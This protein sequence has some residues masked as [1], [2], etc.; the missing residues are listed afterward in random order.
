MV[1]TVSTIPAAGSLLPSGSGSPFLSPPN[2]GFAVT[3]PLLINDPD[4]ILSLFS[5]N[6]DRYYWHDMAWHGME[7][8][9][10]TK[11]AVIASSR[12]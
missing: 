11:H 3:R 7:V 9:V 12:S 8:H 2:L 10:N 5:F 1:T 6:A 4:W